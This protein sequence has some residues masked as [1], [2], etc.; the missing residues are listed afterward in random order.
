MIYA[1]AA[2]AA[3]RLTYMVYQEDG[4]GDVFQHFRELFI[5]YTVLK[6]GYTV[7]KPKNWIGKMLLCF[8]CTSM[9]TVIPVVIYLV[10]LTDWRLLPLE[11]FAM[12]GAAIIIEL[13]RRRIE[14]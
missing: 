10:W 12:S 1:L 14:A 3:W 5:E 6:T 8:Y 11:W 2:L 7:T 9:W 4:P 13:I